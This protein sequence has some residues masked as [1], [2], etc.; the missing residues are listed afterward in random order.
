MRKIRGPQRGR[1]RVQIGAPDA[2]VTGCAGVAVL[3][4]LIDRVGVVEALDTAVGPIKARDRG[5]TAGEFLVSLAQAQLCGHDYLVGLDRCRADVVAT[6]LS[7]VPIPA[8]TT[9]ATL[10]RRLSGEQRLSVEDGL[11]AVS[12]RVLMLR[13]VRRRAVLEHAAPTIDLDTTDTETYGRA[14]A[15]VTFNH[16]GQRVGRTHLAS[17]AQAGISLAVDLRHGPLCQDQVRQLEGQRF[18]AEGVIGDPGARVS[19]GAASRCGCRRRRVGGV[20]VVGSAVG[21][22]PVAAALAAVVQRGVQAGDC[23]GV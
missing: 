17:W 7:A 10:A 2:S 14:K 1:R 11:A 8:A 23:R 3:G 16:T 21:R 19:R 13:P 12:R 4:E 6:E 5:A 15:G 9:A 22:R 20:I 18:T